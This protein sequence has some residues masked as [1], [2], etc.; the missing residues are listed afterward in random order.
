[1]SAIE[2]TFEEIFGQQWSPICAHCFRFVGDPDEAEDL[3]LEAFWKLYKN[4]IWRRESESRVRSW[5]YRVATNDS[6]NAIRGRKRRQQYELEAGLNYLKSSKTLNPASEAERAEER[7][8][9]RQVLSQI[10]KKHASVL[11]LRYA[12]LSYREVADAM[13]ISPKSVGTLLARAEEEFF[14]QFRKMEGR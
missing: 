8:V 2:T 11:S 14:Q 13:R 10:K 4:G 5:L 12:G 1:M 7:R 3:A 9:I 6:L